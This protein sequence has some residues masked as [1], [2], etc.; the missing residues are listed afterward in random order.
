SR[1]GDTLA[2]SITPEALVMDSGE[3]I[4]RIGAAFDS[5]YQPEDSMYALESYGIL[6]AFIKAVDRTWEMSVMTLRILGKM[7]IG[8]ASV[9]NLSG[10]ITIAKYA[11]DTATLGMVAFLGFLA[12]VSV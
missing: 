8:E 10:P 1:N 9:K 11:G 6:P 2:L 4:G 12:I 3:V 7:I 5:R